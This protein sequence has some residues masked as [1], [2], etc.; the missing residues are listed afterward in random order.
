MRRQSWHS[1]AALAWAS[2]LPLLATGPCVAAPHVSPGASPA[3]SARPSAR[4]T[5]APTLAP[6]ATPPPTPEQRARAAFDGIVAGTFDRA[7]LTDGLSRDLSAARLAGYARVLAPLGTPKSFTPV[8]THHVE[9][10]TTYDFLVRY[11]DGAVTFTY[12][13]DDATRLISKL[14][15]RTARS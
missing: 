12:G 5:V 3:A 10:T 8:G 2:A 7:Q 13:L 4:P 11:G 15:I 14:Y 9:G 6:T 1:I